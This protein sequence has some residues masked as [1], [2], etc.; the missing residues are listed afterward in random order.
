MLSHACQAA[1]VSK[2]DVLKKKKKKD[3]HQPHMNGKHRI[4]E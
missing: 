4:L 3:M 2:V 1:K